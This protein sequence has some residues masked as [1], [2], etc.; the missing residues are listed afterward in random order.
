[1]ERGVDH[2]EHAARI[3]E[4]LIVPETENSKAPITKMGIAAAVCE[5]LGVLTAVGFDDQPSLK[6]S[7]IDDIRI[8]HMLTTELR[9]RHAP[10]AKHG[11]KPSLSW[12][13]V[14]PHLAGSVAQFASALSLVIRGHT[15]HPSAAARLPPSPKGEGFC[16]QA[17]H[18]A[19]DKSRTR[20]M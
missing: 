4:H 19:F 13:R 16:S 17:P 8:D 7:K 11:P 2:L 14:G 18:A 3:L 12:G 6:A 5:A 10:V 20:P 15:P 1:M 9:L